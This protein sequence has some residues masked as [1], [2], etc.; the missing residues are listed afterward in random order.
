MNAVQQNLTEQREERVQD[1]IIAPEIS[2]GEREPAPEPVFEKISVQDGDD[3]GTGENVSVMEPPPKEHKK[4]ES[5][6][7][8]SGPRKPAI[9]AGSAVVGILVL[10]A[11]FF[12]FVPS[13][14]P[15]TNLTSPGTNLSIPTVT[16]TASPILPLVTTPA[17]SDTI[18]PA[19]TT[20]ILTTPRTS[21]T[22]EQTPVP[23]VS[24][25]QPSLTPAPG[26]PSTVLISY[27]SLFNAADGAGI[28]ALLAE[29]IKSQYPLEYVNGELDA[30]RSNSYTIENI[31]VRNQIVAG[32]DATLIVDVSWNMGDS[33]ETSTQILLVAYENDQWKL[34]TL[35]LYP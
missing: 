15:G 28:Y 2:T 34:N 8:G 20:I 27:P 25:A 13:V 30:A 35:I 26:D 16:G 17:I 33:S 5:F 11:I 7:A 29:D 19:V 18:G 12:M 10:I 6:F 9:I 21:A 24:S 1:D 4:K 31:N 14:S 32:S 22:A 23:E 3:S